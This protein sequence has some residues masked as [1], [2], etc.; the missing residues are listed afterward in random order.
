MSLQ[1]H[2]GNWSEWEVVRRQVAVC[3]CVIADAALLGRVL[4]R[5]RGDQVDR[6]VE[7]RR[8][9]I[10]F[11]LDLPSGDYVMTVEEADPRD[12]TSVKVFARA[13]GH[14]SRNARGDV[15]FASVDLDTTASTGQPQARQRR[16]RRNP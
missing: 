7:I 11:F 8:D 3:G 10:Y 1:P 14:V 5:A 4:V 12:G 13:T 16:R 2:D 9:G 6:K 15:S